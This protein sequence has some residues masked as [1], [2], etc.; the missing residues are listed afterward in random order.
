MQS[1]RSPKPQDTV[2]FETKW[3]NIISRKAAD[4]PDPHYVIGSPDFAVVIALDLS[5]NLLLVRQ[6]RH[7]VQAHTLELPS[8]HVEVGESPEEAARKELLEETGY[9]AE[10]FELLTDFSVSTARFSNRVWCYLARN[11]R[12]QPQTMI[13]HGLKLVIHTQG[14]RGLVEEKEFCNAVHYGAICHALLSGKLQA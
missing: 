2:V 12:P 6:Y 7:G 11:A 13:E 8:G 4:S 9:I 1:S 3:F 5:G 14:L 10:T